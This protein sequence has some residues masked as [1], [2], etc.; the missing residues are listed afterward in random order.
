MSFGK[1]DGFGRYVDPAGVQMGWFEGGKKHGNVLTTDHYGII[2]KGNTGLYD[3]D[4]YE[5]DFEEDMPEDYGRDKQG[6]YF[7]EKNCVKN[8]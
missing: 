4:Y 6:K 1:R 2:D 5:E 3:N 8:G 7:N